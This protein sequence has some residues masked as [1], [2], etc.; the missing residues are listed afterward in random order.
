MKKL[1][2]TAAVAASILAPALASAQTTP[3]TVACASLPNPVYT[4][5]STALRNFV[6]IVGKLLAAD[7]SPTTVVYQAQGSCTGVQKIYDADAAKRT[8]KDIP[9]AGST[10]ANY[11]VFVKADGSVQECSLDNTIGTEVNIGI[12][13]VFAKSCGINEA[14]L[15]VSVT[16]YLGPVQPMLFVVPAS[17]QQ[18]SI[19]YEAAYMA[20]GLG[21]N[22]GKAAPWIDPRFFFIRNASS[23]TQ[24]MLAAAI[25]VPAA[26]WWGVNRGGA[27]QVRDQL[28]IV[29]DPAQ[30]NSAIGILSSDVVDADRANLRAL[31]Y[32]AKGQTCGY[33]PDSSAIAKDKQNVRDGH[34]EVWGASH[35]FARTS[36]GT[37]TSTAAQAFLARFVTPRLPPELIDAVIAG[38]LIPQCAMKVTRSEELGPIASFNPPYSCGCYF[39]NATRGGTTCKACKDNA[40]C[41]GGVR[42][43]CNYGFCEAR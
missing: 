33:L 12:S 7:A 37:P 27:S 15:G 24:Q 1:V 28:K 6:Y 21:G 31:A 32:R 2:F 29:V 4:A 39:D 16:D 43:V 30:A 17:S 9:Q 41:G 42:P 38:A 40:E 25:G 20:F 11:A 14:P 35:L 36:N 18:T 3:P 5:G 8:I 19:S 23:G 26:K 10:P 22:G 34:Y 13:D